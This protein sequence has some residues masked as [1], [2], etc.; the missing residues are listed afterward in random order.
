MQEI[1]AIQPEKG[2]KVMQIKKVKNGIVPI[3]R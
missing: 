2:I 3:Y 1:L